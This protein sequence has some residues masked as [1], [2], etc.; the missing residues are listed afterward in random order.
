MTAE[1]DLQRVAVEALQDVADRGVRRC[2][3]PGQ[4][5]R[6]VQ[7]AAVRVDEGGDAAIRVAAADDRQGR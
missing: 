2:A 1:S 5:E 7:A 3:P 4:P 6:P